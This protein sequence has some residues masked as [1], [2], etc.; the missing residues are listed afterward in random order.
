MKPPEIVEFGKLRGERAVRFVNVQN[1]EIAVEGWTSVCLVYVGTT[2]AGVIKRE[3]ETKY[4]KFIPV[5]EQLFNT[6]SG[7]F[8]L[9]ALKVRVAEWLASRP[10]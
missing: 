5:E 6:V 9:D 2:R 4:H 10:D 8:S 3:G 7:D 1:R